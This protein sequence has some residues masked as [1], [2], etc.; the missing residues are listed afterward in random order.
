MNNRVAVRVARAA[1]VAG[2]VVGCSGGGNDLVAAARVPETP[3]LVSAPL[4]NEKASAAAPIALSPASA[5]AGS[6]DLEVTATVALPG[7][8]Y[9]TTLVWSVD[10]H[11]T[12]LGIT[13]LSTTDLAVTIPAALMITPATA[14]VYVQYQDM[15]GNLFETD[16][17]AFVVSAPKAAPTGGMSVARSGH[18]ATLLADG[19]VLLVGGDAG[20]RSAEVYDPNDGVFV[21]TGDMTSAH[22]GAAA[23]LLAGGKVL[24]TGGYD[25]DS[26]IAPF[27][28]SSHTELY[29]PQLGTFAATGS[30]SEARNGH[31]ATLLAD[32]RVVIAG[33]N[34]AGGGGGAALA[35]AE[36]FE[37]A[38]GTFTRVG[39]MSSARADHATA[40]LQSGDVLVVGGWNGH[41]AD[42]LD[43]PPWDPLFAEL[44]NPASGTFSATQ[45]MSTTRPFD[46]LVFVLENGSVLVLG[47]YSPTEL[48]NIHEQPRHAAFAELYAPGSGTFWP[49]STTGF[50]RRNYTGTLLSDGTVL[51]VGG[52]N[53]AGPLDIIESF[54]PA[55]GA[56]IGV[57]RL[58]T[59]RVGH[60]ATLLQSGRV[61][62]TGGT[63]GSGNALATAELWPPD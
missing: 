1:V 15:D 24:V 19:Q 46:P 33:G 50:T 45:A 23:V 8:R 56:L 63:D 54:D 2:S 11:H 37:P 51:I 22:G 36:V 38:T 49:L 6:A 5:T 32:G 31:T 13:W 25:L 34:R 20:G 53:D 61:L 42:S 29:D 47:G 44:F 55:N 3:P 28:P 4:C 62:I 30:M 26:T 7:H 9:Q 21:P 41:R 14:L 57:G 43:D 18:T 48:Q 35:S 10:C 12:P 16:A 40:V 27:P 52:E 59:A 17:V 39:D 60:S 58:I